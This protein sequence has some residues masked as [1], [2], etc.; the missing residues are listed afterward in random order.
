M[1]QIT[2]YT[3]FVWT[4]LAF[5]DQMMERKKERK[6]KGRTFSRVVGFAGTKKRTRKR[7]RHACLDF[8]PFRFGVES[9]RAAA[10]PYTKLHR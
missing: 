8:L 4:V 9:L 3:M 1:A 6:T 5:L 10:P 2:F 7:H